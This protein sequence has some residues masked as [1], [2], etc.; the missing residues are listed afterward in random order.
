MPLLLLRKKATA[1]YRCYNCCFQDPSKGVLAA[2][3]RC[4]CKNPLVSSAVAPLG[5]EL[6]SLADIFRRIHE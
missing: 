5:R 2:R 3:L 1:V 6:S 4:C